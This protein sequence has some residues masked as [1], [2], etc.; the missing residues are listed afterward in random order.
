MV[1]AL[2]R[3][4]EYADQEIAKGLAELDA[5]NKAIADKKAE[6]HVDEAVGDAR[7]SE[8]Q[9]NAAQAKQGLPQDIWDKIQAAQSTSIGDLEGKVNEMKEMSKSVGECLTK[10]LADAQ[11]EQLDYVSCSP[12]RVPIARLAAA[13]A[14]IKSR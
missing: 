4:H 9:I 12:F 7:E 3:Y 1:D 8:A 2:K 10:L 11:Q 14:A 13:Q 6:L 5:Y